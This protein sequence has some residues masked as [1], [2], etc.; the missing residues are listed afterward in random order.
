MGLWGGIKDALGVIAPFAGPVLGGIIS[1][2]GQSS[3][4]WSNRKIA[5]DNRA[6]QE[7]MSSSAV[8][9]HK[10]DMEKA[11]LNP[12]LAAGGQASTPGGSTAVMQNT[13][14]QAAASAKE[15]PQLAAQVKLTR[16]Q[17]KTEASKAAM[18]DAAATSHSAQ[19]IKTG[20]ESGLSRAKG[21]FGLRLSSGLSN[22]FGKMDAAKRWSAQKHPL[23]RRLWDLKPRRKR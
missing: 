8:T 9:R 13:L 15:I 19:A 17:A 6:F 18:M 23:M 3:A 14:E 10:A 11:G 7:R 12:I 2:S 4:N 5:E 16:A 20:Y 21:T 1:E 22:L